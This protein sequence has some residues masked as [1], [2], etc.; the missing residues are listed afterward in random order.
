MNA[1]PLASIAELAKRLN[2]PEEQAK[3]FCQVQ[4]ELAW[5]S[6]ARG[7]PYIVPGI[8]MFRVFHR[9]ARQLMTPFGAKPSRPT[10]IPAKK[11]IK[12]HVSKLA[13][14]AVFDPPKTIP[15]VTQMEIQEEDETSE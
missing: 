15:D 12:V 9:G 13:K 7:E 11:L 6:L 14:N 3:R 1:S 8:G 5:E 2:I 10:L 4:A